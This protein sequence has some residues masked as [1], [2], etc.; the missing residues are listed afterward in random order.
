MTTVQVIIPCYNYGRYLSACV[1][2]AVS[3]RDVD[4]NVLI[5]DDQSS[6]DTPDICR[7]LASEHSRV[8]YIRH[9][10]NRR[11]IATYNE[12]LDQA[13][14]DYVVLLSADDLLTPGCLARAT[15]L[16]DAAPDVGFTFGNV[17]DLERDGSHQRSYPFGNDPGMPARRIMSG[18]EFIR[19]NGAKNIVPTPTV[20]VRE[21]LQRKVGGY[22][23]ELPH[24]GDMEMWLRLASHAGVG[25]INDDQGIYRRHASNMSLG[26]FIESKLPDLRQRKKA[27]DMLFSG[28][29]PNLKQDQA[30]RDFLVEDLAR[31]ALRQAGAAFNQSELAAAEA[32]KGF[33]LEVSPRARRSL[34]WA[35]LAFKQTIGPRNW[36]ALSSILRTSAGRHS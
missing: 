15:S 20:V 26:Y 31:E 14:G 3:Q 22:L 36:H 33:A 8:T 23:A 29:G 12:G 25:F 7:Q 24:T 1:E 2:S 4:V 16:M 13:R 10:V 11:H 21:S 5:I 35:K 27:L 32:I 9:A 18:P 6:D 34:P 17:I 28:A 30:L 19:L